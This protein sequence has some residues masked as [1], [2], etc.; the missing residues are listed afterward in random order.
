VANEVNARRIN[1]EL[2]VFSGLFVSP[3]FMSVLLLTGLFQALIMN[4]LGSFFK[5]VPLNWQE[6]LVTMAI[7]AGAFPVSFLTR[8]IT[9]IVE[10]RQKAK[11]PA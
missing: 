4:F 1:D 7:G 10:G 2:N 6:W 5:V 3:I 8:L 11:L 9:Q